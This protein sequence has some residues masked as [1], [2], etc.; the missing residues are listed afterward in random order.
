MAETMRMA[1]P[2]KPVGSLM[3]HFGVKNALDPR[4]SKDFLA[5]MA[6]FQK[7][8]VDDET[9]L[10][11]V[12]SYERKFGQAETTAARLG[13]VFKFL[14]SIEERGDLVATVR[15]LGM[16]SKAELEEYAV[17]TGDWGHFLKRVEKEQ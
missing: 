12:R 11:V 3:G 17:E 7:H 4:I 14:S 2:L 6:L 9:A 5:L 16:A 15:D 1:V 8:K 13:K 10:E